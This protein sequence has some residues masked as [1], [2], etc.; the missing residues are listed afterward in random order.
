MVLLMYCVLFHSIL[1]ICIEKT[2]SFFNII[3]IKIDRKAYDFPGCSDSKES[4]CNVE[5][6]IRSLGLEDPLEK[7]MVTHSSILDKL[8]TW[9]QQEKMLNV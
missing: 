1:S 6:W 9:T 4:D 7:G 5:T 3:E 2:C 8:L